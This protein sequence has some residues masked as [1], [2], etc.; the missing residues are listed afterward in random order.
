VKSLCG[1]ATFTAAEFCS[2]GEVLGK[3]GGTV[4]YNPA[5]ENCCGSNKYTLATQFCQAGTNEVKSLC[6]GATF[7]AAK[8]CSG[9][10]VLG[11]CG[12]TVEYNSATQFCQTGTNEVKDLCGGETYTSAEGCCGGSKYTI[13]SQFCQAGSNAVKELCGG[14]EFTAAQFCSGTSIVGKCGGTVEYAPSTEGCCGS[15]KYTLASQGCCG[16]ATFTQ[17]SH[18][19]YASSSKVGSFCGNNPQKSYDPDKYECKPGTN[20]N[21]IYLKTVLTDGRDSKTY[22]AVL[23]GTQTWMAKNLNYATGGKCGYGSSLS[24]NNTSSCDTYGRLY[25][26]STAMAG[27]ATS[28]KN[29]SEV[30]GVC[31]TGWHIPSDAEWNALM[32]YVNP[33]CADNSD[34]A[35]AG[36]KLKATRGWYSNGNGTDEYGFSALP[37]GDG[38]YSSNDT[39][40]GLN[41]YW[42]SATEDDASAYTRRMNYNYA[43]VNRN[44]LSKAYLFSVRCVQD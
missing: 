14:A 17:A 5:T 30:N 22:E 16:T 20:A 7:T 21:G 9:G 18:F 26:W 8:F 35:D 28:S 40:Y 36:T 33:S 4:E 24:D 32:K 34:C 42:W 38:Y 10:E 13:A 43:G 15:N 6:G 23:I 19:C 27:S 11:K 12:G 37:G 2:G 25:N 44:N 29:P 31:P 3:C 1:G 41:G 39:N